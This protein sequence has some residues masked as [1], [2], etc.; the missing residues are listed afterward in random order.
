MT[1]VSRAPLEGSY[2]FAQVLEDERAEI[3]RQCECEERGVASDLELDGPTT[4]R[5]PDTMGVAFSG[6][7]IR[8]AC[9]G[10]GV[11]QRMAQAGILRQ[12]HYI[13]AISGGGY[14]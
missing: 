12:T 2:N 14:L 3:K 4:E 5:G 11:L 6:G 1:Q 7:G 8:S 13:S 10:M 9:V